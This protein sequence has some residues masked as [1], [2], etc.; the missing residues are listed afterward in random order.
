MATRLKM[1]LLRTL[2]ELQELSTDELL[3]ARYEKFRSI[4]TFTES[5]SEMSG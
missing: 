2:R 5:V 3:A 4:G 1:Y